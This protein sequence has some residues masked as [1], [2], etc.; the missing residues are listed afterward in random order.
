MEYLATERRRVHRLAGA[1]GL[2]TKREA[3]KTWPRHL[4]PSEFAELFPVHSATWEREPGQSDG[5]F[6][7]TYRPWD[8]WATL[9]F[10]DVVSGTFALSLLKDWARE[11]AKS[12]KSHLSLAIGM[13]LQDRRAPHFHILLEVQKNADGFDPK[14]ALRLWRNLS[15]RCGTKNTFE[16]FDPDRRGGEYLTKFGAWGFLVACPRWSACRRRGNCV[17][18][19]HAW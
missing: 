12:Q 5:E 13:E 11:L 4:D 6:V 15:K 2:N 1:T 14:T 19:P 18:D 10:K 9:T 16:R 7:Q 8:W 3:R 17:I